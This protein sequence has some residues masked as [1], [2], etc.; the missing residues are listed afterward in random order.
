[1]SS[2]DS[3]DRDSQDLKDL[4]AAYALGALDPAEARS[5]EA[6]LATSPEARRE[7]AEFREVATLL[8]TTTAGAGPGPSSDL[9]DRV[10]ARV[11]K[12]KVV[13][14]RPAAARPN[15][16]PWAAAAAVLLAV[17]FG[18]QSIALRR[19]VAERDAAI[20]ELRRDFGATQ[21]Q[22]AD[23]RGNPE[24][25]PGARCTPHDP[26]IDLDARTGDSALH[27]SEEAG[28]TDS[29]L[30]PA[31][32]RERTG[33]PA[34]VHPQGR[35]ADSLGDVQRGADR[36]CHGATG[37]NSGSPEPRCRR[38]HQ[39]TCWWF[40]P[41]HDPAHP[42]WDDRELNYCESVKAVVRSERFASAI[43][44]T[45]IASTAAHCLPLTA[46]RPRS[47]SSRSGAHS[48]FGWPTP[49]IHLWPRWPSRPSERGSRS[50]RRTPTSRSRTRRA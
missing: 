46:H 47:T 11:A 18:L 15:W 41:A 28:G 29:R 42:G 40:A 13:P 4:A 14:L 27:E 35:Q 37:R 43:R 12:E 38:G 48:P 45:L 2:A 7:V 21:A 16:I 34:L 49:P 3:Q 25:D 24:C 20:A 32:D 23:A 39:R 10:L 19:Q 31:A 26:D 22:L 5:F 17:G 8:A 30:Q 1:M 9:R 6:F 36:A 50:D 44:I 33:L